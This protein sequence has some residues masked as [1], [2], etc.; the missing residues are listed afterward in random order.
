[1]EGTSEAAPEAVGRGCHEARVACIALGHC[2]WRGTAMPGKKPAHGQK[3]KAPTPGV[4]W[5]RSLLVCMGHMEW[6]VLARGS[7]ATQCREPAAGFC[8]G[9]G[10]GGGAGGEVMDAEVCG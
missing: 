2:S 6:R 7:V 1:M 10:G 5:P 4:V 9:R 3:L 8:G